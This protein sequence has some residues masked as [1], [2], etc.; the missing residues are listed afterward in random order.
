MPANPPSLAE[1]IKTGCFSIFVACFLIKICS[2]WQQLVECLELRVEGQRLVGS[3]S[4]VEGQIRQFL[5]SL[6]PRPTGGHRPIA[7]VPPAAGPAWSR[8]LTTTYETW[9]AERGGIPI[10]RAIGFIPTAEEV[11]AAVGD[12]LATEQIDALI[13]GPSGSARAIATPSRG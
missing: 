13:V 5:L 10:S 11:D 12:I 9:I 4:R 3:A 7:A 6:D 8:E 2:S 1:C